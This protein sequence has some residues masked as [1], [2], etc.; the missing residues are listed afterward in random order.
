M[1]TQR[2]I[3]FFCIVSYFSWHIYTFS[4]SFF[5]S[6]MSSFN[7]ENRN[8]TYL[9]NAPRGYPPIKWVLI[10]KFSSS[11]EFMLSRSVAQLI[12]RNGTFL[13]TGLILEKHGTLVSQVFF[14]VLSFRVLR[15][16]GRRRIFFG[17][18][19]LFLFSSLHFGLFFNFYIHFPHFPLFPLFVMFLRFLSISYYFTLQQ[20]YFSHC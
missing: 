3:L 15:K 14:Q 16:K 6:C 11:N 5:L 18:S 20:I 7:N 8:F 1:I 13:C 9:S 4:L 17:G 12:T 2:S 19:L 10:L